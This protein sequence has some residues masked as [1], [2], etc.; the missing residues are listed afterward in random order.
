MTVAIARDWAVIILA[1]FLLLQTLMVT[2]LSIALWRAVVS[3]R[4]KL[5]PIL[6]NAKT[7]SGNVAGTTSI[8]ADVVVK[9][10]AKTWGFA[11][12]V[13]QAISF[14]ARFTRRSRKERDKK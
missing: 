7:A 13:R 10:L 12:G 11:V 1:V 2:I 8:V 3:L 9:P 14:I 5:E 6:D 4:K